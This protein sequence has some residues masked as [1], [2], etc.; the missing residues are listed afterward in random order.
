[1]AQAPSQGNHAP[2]STTSGTCGDFD[3]QDPD[4][5]E[6]SQLLG[7][8]KHDPTLLGI[9]ALGKDGVLRS[10]TADRDVVDAIGLTPGLITAF[11]ARLPPHAREDFE[12]VDGSTT[13]REQ[14]YNPDKSQ[15]PKPLSE[16]KRAEALRTI[17][18]NKELFDKHRQRSKLGDGA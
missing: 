9:I 5:Q 2:V 12:G 8:L 6:L 4:Q 7:D 10:L 13:T 3:R 14:R 11:M 18:E 16:E 17:E 1:M 15:L